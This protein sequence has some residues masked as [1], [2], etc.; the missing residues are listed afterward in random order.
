MNEEPKPRDDFAP[1]GCGDVLFKTIAVIVFAVV[2][3]VLLGVALRFVGCD[4]G[5]R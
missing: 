5:L 1:G 3:L 4:S 2:A